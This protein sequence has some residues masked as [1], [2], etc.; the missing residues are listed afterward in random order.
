MP[1]DD[2]RAERIARHLADSYRDNAE[3]YP[4][5]R[6]YWR[7]RAEGADGVAQALADEAVIWAAVER[8]RL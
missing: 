3:K 8:I 6:D 4:A 1:T 5:D 2:D 7:A